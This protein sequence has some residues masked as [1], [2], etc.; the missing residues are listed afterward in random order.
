M[1]TRTRMCP[2]P[3]SMIVERC[4]CCCR[5]CRACVN[6]PHASRHRQKP[7]T[8]HW[9]PSL[10]LSL[11]LLPSLF[12]APKQSFSSF[13]LILDFDRFK[14]NF[15][16]LPHSTS[17]FFLHYF[18]LFLLQKYFINNH[19]FCRL[20]SISS[21]ILP[22]TLLR[23]S[24]SFFSFFTFVHSSKKYPGKDESSL[25]GLPRRPRP[26]VTPPDHFPA[27]QLDRRQASHSP[28]GS[29]PRRA[30]RSPDRLEGRHR[31]A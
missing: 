18:L 20:I 28:L 2:T 4:C 13:S 14:N 16:C 23:W 12:Y 11:S 21:F 1:C 7:A 15:L 24:T 10:S 9:P 22:L 27:C 31:P 30:L 8:K 26:A 6:C 5:G 19:T 17:D 3:R 29:C 25:D